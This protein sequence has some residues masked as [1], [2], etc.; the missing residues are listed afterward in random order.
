MNV[1]LQSFV[2]NPLLRNF[3]LSDGHKSKNCDYD[4]CMSCAMDEM[5]QDLRY[6]MRMLLK[7]KGLYARLW[8]HQSGGFIEE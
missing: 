8:A 4:H 5:F 1:I 3:Y 2:H 6:G 7:H